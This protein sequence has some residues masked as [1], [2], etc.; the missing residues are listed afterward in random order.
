[1]IVNRGEGAPALVG[2]YVN[3]QCPLSLASFVSAHVENA[4]APVLLAVTRP[5]GTRPLAFTSVT[6]TVHV[7][8]FPTAIESGE[9]LT[10][11]FVESSAT[12]SGSDPSLAA[13]P[14]SPE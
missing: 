9:Q 8:V 1:M 13:L 11:V 3:V 2:L 6:V 12:P 10:A 7:V 14:P 5:P 4:P